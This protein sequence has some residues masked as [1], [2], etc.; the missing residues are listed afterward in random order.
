MKLMDGLEP[1]RLAEWDAQRIDRLL[2]DE[3][4]IRNRP[5]IEAAVGNARCYLELEAA[6][7][8]FFRAALGSCRGADDPSMPGVTCVRS[9]IAPPNPNP[10]PV[11]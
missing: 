4:I 2:G 8:C 10:W 1:A 6:G 7:G 9:L 11:T 5:K 3:R